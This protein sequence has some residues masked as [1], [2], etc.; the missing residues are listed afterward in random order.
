MLDRVAAG[1]DKDWPRGHSPRRGP[2]LHAASHERS[3]NSS[4]A[5]MRRRVTGTRTSGARSDGSSVLRR[6]V[7]ASTGRRRMS[8]TVAVVLNALRT[9][10]QP[11]ELTD[12]ERW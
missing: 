4:D 1:Q 6:S 11:A 3:R 7:P 8:A 5:G 10:R 2:R 12:F 9:A